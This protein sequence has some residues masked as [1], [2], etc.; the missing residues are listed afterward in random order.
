LRLM[1]PSVLAEFPR[2]WPSSREF[3]WF[4]TFGRRAYCRR[5][6]RFNS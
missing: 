4:D 5:A 3:L 1:N 6:N 2:Q